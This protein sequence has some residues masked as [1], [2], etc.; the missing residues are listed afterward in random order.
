MGS[1]LI[2]DRPLARYKHTGHPLLIK[3]GGN[4]VFIPSGLD[5]VTR[6]PQLGIAGL[7]IAKIISSISSFNILTPMEPNMVFDR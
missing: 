4:C 7:L 3:Q 6:H 5:E 1:I 2:S